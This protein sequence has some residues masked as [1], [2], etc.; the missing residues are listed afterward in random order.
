MVEPGLTADDILQAVQR[1]YHR[2]AIVSEISINDPYWHDWAESGDG[3]KRTLKPMRRIDALMMETHDLTA[4]EIK[5]DRTDF[6]RDT[7][8][9]R[10][11]WQRVVNR[12]IYAVPADLKV[13]APHGCGLWKVHGD[14]KIEVAKRAIINKHPEYLPRDVIQRLMYK[15]AKA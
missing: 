8:E 15:A 4:I 7:L 9:K 3:L 14:G 6:K 5:V 10:R 11:P 12:F 1:K 2:A 13:T